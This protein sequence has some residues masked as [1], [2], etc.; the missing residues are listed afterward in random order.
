M[1][2]AT[3]AIITRG[4]Q[5]LLGRKQGGSEIGEGTLNGPGGKQE[6]GETIL[7][8]LVRE[9]K[10]EVGIILNPEKVEKCAILTFYAG[11]VKDFKVHVFRASVFTGE[12]RETE[13]MVPAWYDIDDL[14]SKKVRDR[15]LE[16]DRAWFLQAVEGEKFCAN[17]YYLER[18]K[19]FIK[20]EFLPFA[21]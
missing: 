4:N 1:K 20:I 16:S 7:Q 19:G 21:A 2:I 13:S 12:P 10:E 14:S 11:G 3:L 17:V 8:C 18:A 5:V 15:M 9:V 6:P